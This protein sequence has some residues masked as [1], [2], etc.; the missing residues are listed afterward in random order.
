MMKKILCAATFACMLIPT[1]VQAQLKT[2]SQN[3][4]QLQS[5]TSSRLDSQNQAQLQSQTSSR[6]DSQNQAQLQ[7]QTSSQLDSQAQTQ[8]QSP[9][10]SQLDSPAQSRT[11]SRL[12][13]PVQARFQSQAQEEFGLKYRKYRISFVPGL[14]TN[15]TEATNYTAKY[16][17]NLIAG[18][19]GGLDGLEVGLININKYY[20]QGAQFGAL[21]LSGGDLS[22]LQFGAAANIAR[23]PI[24]GLQFAGGINYAG[25]AMKGIQFASLTN[26]TE[27]DMQGI[28][29]SGI[30]NYSGGSMQ[31][32]QLSGIGNIALYDIQGVQLS[33]VF[34]VNTGYAQ[35]IIGAGA[36]NFSGDVAQ[37]IMMAGGFNFSRE[38]Q[39]VA[40]AGGLNLS[41]TMQGI[42]VAGGL[43]IAN[44]G[45]GIQ[46][47]PVN[48]AREFE[49]VPV[50]LVSLYGNGRKN[51][52]VWFSD[53]GF[54]NIGFKTGTYEVHNMIS[55]G[56]NTLIQ[57][58]DVWTL[59]W[60]IGLHRELDLLWKNDRFAGYFLN[61]EYSIQKINE[62][63]I[64]DD[65]N[66]IYTYKY[67]LGKE[68]SPSFSAYAG[69]TLNLMISDNVNNDDY[70]WYS[71]YDTSARGLDYR[72]W[73]G[74]TVGIQMF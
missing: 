2:D 53:G 42:Q 25:G 64:A 24:Q 6:L 56:Y 58:R 62:G 28:Q 29:M 50:G 5:Q 15:G 31:G 11:S 38:L 7:S 49:G 34:N 66:S 68:F 46:I 27:S 35:G 13:S 55:V 36:F 72:F 74:F 26:A 21:N 37:G 8:L 4:A 12:D 47:A 51:I 59:G 22:G 10:L 65:V 17:L 54:T 69:P 19:N 40:V 61:Q 43:N 1:G 41:E 44:F 52:D 3:Q 39:G 70:I 16:S 45:Q 18:Y 60:K 67:L 57:D 9:T 14:S 30:L 23:G 73:V 48:I 63:K 71:I 20:A 32:I 33:G